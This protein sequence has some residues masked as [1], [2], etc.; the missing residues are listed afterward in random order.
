MGA[1]MGVVVF[2]NGN[3]ITL[4]P[5]KPRAGAVAVRDSRII[6]VG[7]DEEVVSVAGKNAKVIDLQ[8][9]T[10]LPGFAD[11]HVHLIE[12]GLILSSAILDIRGAR[13][14]DDIKEIVRRRA[15]EKPRGTWI[16]GHGW[17]TT[18][19]AERRPPN[20]W[21]LD[22]VAPNNPVM[23]TD[24]GWHV[25]SVNSL[26]LKLAN[27]RKGTESPPGGKIDK[28]PDT[29]EPIGVLR[30]TATMKIE[31][32]ITYSDEE[33]I[34]ALN[35]A[36]DE[37]VRLGLTSVHCA[38]ENAQNIRVFQELLMRDELPLR[39]Y[40]MIPASL[41]PNL[42]GL[43]LFTGFGNPKLKI[44]AIKVMLD[45]TIGRRTAASTQ[46]YEGEP[47]NL[48]LLSLSEEELYDLVSK[49]HKAGFQL[50]IHAIG[51]RAIRVAL[52]SIERILKE[53]PKADHRHRIEHA[54]MLDE[55]LVSR[56][57]N[58][59]VIASV[60]PVFISPNMDWMLEPLGHKRATE[61]CMRYRTLLDAGVKVTAGSDCPAD[62]TMSPLVG[63]QSA[64][65]RHGFALGERISVEQA[66]PLYTI[67]SA[68][69]SFEEKLRGSIEV[70]KLADLAVLSDNP[71]AMPTD[72]I[73]DIKVDMTIVDGEV[74]YNR[75]HL[76]QS[77]VRG[78]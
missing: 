59:G 54:S 26:A 31:E 53:K 9:R 72:R 32:L 5:S 56:M 36:L 68:Y 13:S 57:R 70:G 33:L 67:N 22:E 62:S 40:L 65:T 23:I 41:L 39:V 17:S 25:C 10:V 14:I 42:S 74:V 19:L 20:K 63:I 73:G 48:G 37:A 77:R 60:Q 1:V 30:E 55:E 38:Y 52:D 18:D 16:T 61:L 3:V 6:G 75:E 7:T 49:A 35:Y 45:G 69:A 8:G 76:Q 64:V 47:D 44:G 29:G 11:S 71:L 58:L 4:D 34:T 24:V 15:I 21:D 12:Y 2:V 46:P 51:D 66:I 50:A 78:S 27:I 43:G 28:D